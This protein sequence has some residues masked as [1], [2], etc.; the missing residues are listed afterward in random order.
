M[1]KNL[2][3]ILVLL[4]TN[5]ASAEEQYQGKNFKISLKPNGQYAILTFELANNAKFY[6]RNPGELGLPTI[7]SFDESNNL[8]SAKTYWPIPKLY[9]SHNTNSYVYQGKTE[10]II[11]PIAKNSQQNIA[12]NLDISFGICQESCEAFDIPLSTIIKPKNAPS[13][14]D[15]LLAKMPHENG[16]KGLAIETLEQECID[17]QHYLKIKINSDLPLNSP[18]IFIDL[19]VYV[20]FDPGKF[21]LSHEGNQHLISIP[22]TILDKKHKFIE[23]KIYL[24]LIADNGHTI[25]YKAEAKT[26]ANSGIEGTFL[27]IIICALLGGL[28][29]NIMPCVLPVLALKIYQIAKIAEQ[30][31]HS[32]KKSL[33]AQALGIITSFMGVA[34]ISY[35]LQQ[36]GHQVGFGLQF[37]QPIYLISLVI[38]L[39]IVATSLVSDS[40]NISL[41]NFIMKLFPS[42]PEKLGM[43]GFFLTGILTVLLAIPCTAPFITVAVAFALTADFLNM[44]TIFT[45]IGIGM[46]FP[47][48][49]LAIVPRGT[50]L[51]PKP[52]E[53]MSKIKQILGLGIFGAALWLIYIISTQL[54][55]KAAISLF[56]LTI[57]LKF[58]LTE[59]ELFSS[60][61]KP[62]I[63]LA[64]M[65]LCFFVPQH[66]YQEKYQEEILS[67][68]FWQEYRPHRIEALIEDDKIILVDVTASWCL[69]CSFNKNMTMEN[70]AVINF[71][72]K[73]GVIGMRAD[74]SEF[75]SDEVS[76]LMREHNHYGIPLNIIYSKKHPNGMVLPT[77]LMPE[78]LIS[79]L[80]KAM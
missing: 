53:W 58:I 70:E 18:Q 16:S 35:G 25:E 30:D 33:L 26:S 71:M 3:I 36:F 78:K 1:F 45:F 6:W 60:K 76:A 19:P 65:A 68:E 27:W 46:A 23:E 21:E 28:I 41:P 77:I 15:S 51:I 63:I 11:K 24:N 31:K 9:N 52:G 57:L 56:L 50:F 34:I 5:I 79:A 32:I 20:Q 4:L 67:E 29:L 37:Q 13:N 14:I 47:Y 62:I 43:L 66:L 69:S 48:L 49:L 42:N 8:S 80:K 55:Y 74:I 61:I 17:Q 10:F 2:I 73:I 38:I 40:F 64:I 72:E 7:F 12:L 44:L 75:N 59:K 39:T 22:F 54:G